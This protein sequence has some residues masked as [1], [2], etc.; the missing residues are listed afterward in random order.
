MAAHGIR[1]EVVVSDNGSVDGSIDVAVAAGAR[2]VSCPT[3]GYGAALRFGF[4]CAHG[5]GTS[6][7]RMETSRMISRCSRGSSRKR[8]L[9][10]VSSSAPA[11]GAISKRRD[12]APQSLL[13]HTRADLDL[14]R[15]F[16]TR[17]SDCNCGMRCIEA[18]IRSFGLA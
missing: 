4:S 10:P 6:S 18:G 16:G 13:R 11:C 1:G 2:V 12:A 5:T 8:E 7:W 17:I 14:N 3:R 15:L 9:E